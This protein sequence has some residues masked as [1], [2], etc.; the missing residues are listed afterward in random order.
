M[1]KKIMGDYAPITTNENATLPNG[2]VYDPNAHVIM[3]N[4]IEPETKVYVS[5]GEAV[6]SATCVGGF[7]QSEYPLAA[8]LVS[9]SVGESFPNADYLS[10]E[11]YD[12]YV[13][14][15][16]EFGDWGNE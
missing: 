15:N 2:T 10:F 3:C 8:A 7:E 4:D 13:T 11:A 9:E 12:D 6:I 1:N 14:V 5:D 16:I